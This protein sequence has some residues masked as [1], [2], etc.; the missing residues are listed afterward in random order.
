MGP[1]KLLICFS[2]TFSENNAGGLLFI[3]FFF[4]EIPKNGVQ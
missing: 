1:K 4:E 2:G 3:I